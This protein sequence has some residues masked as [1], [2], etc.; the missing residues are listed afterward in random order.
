MVPVSVVVPRLRL[1]RRSVV[2]LRA[3][4][5]RLDGAADVDS[6]EL[7]AG[8]AVVDGALGVE[9]PQATSAHRRAP[10]R[11]GSGPIEGCGGIRVIPG[12]NQCAKV[13][14]A[15]GVRARIHSSA[16]MAVSGRLGRPPWLHA[17]QYEAAR[18]GPAD[19]TGNVFPVDRAQVM[20]T[21]DDVRAVAPLTAAQLRDVG[22]GRGLKFRVGQRVPAFSRDESLLGFAFPVTGGAGGCRPCSLSAAQARRHALQLARGPA[23][24]D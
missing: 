1:M 13:G 16:L 11:P 9:D 2:R 24:D 21:I 7:A 18:G 15:I 12:T 20:A 3:P 19:M 14:T 8:G 23:G 17:S 4:G 10:H 5:P 22:P 6:A